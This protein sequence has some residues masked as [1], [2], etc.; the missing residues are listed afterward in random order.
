M[1][2]MEMMISSNALG[3]IRIAKS[4]Q[5]VAKQI[6]LNAKFKINLYIPLLNYA[7]FNVGNSIFSKHFLISSVFNA[8]L[9]AKNALLIK[10]MGVFL[11]KIPSFITI[12]SVFRNAQILQWEIMQRKCVQKNAFLGNIRMLRQTY[13]NNVNRPAQT[14]N[15]PPYASHALRTIFF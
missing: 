11:V 15:L 13:A 8:I 9:L 14:V 5:E 2:I 4:V 6:A 7:L 1:A 12:T 3:V 10:K